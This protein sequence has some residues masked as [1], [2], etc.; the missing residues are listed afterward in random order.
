VAFGSWTWWRVRTSGATSLG[1]LVDDREADVHVVEHR[2]RRRPEAAVLDRVADGHGG[3]AGLGLDA[4]GE[5]QELA[6]HGRLP[7]L[8]LGPQHA[9][10]ALPARPVAQE[11]R[12]RVGDAAVQ[13]VTDF[14]AVGVG[15]VAR[16]LL[17]RAHD[18]VEA[19][20]AHQPREGAQP[21]QA[22]LSVVLVQP[23][24]PKP[25]GRAPAERDAVE[26]QC[27]HV[28]RPVDHQLEGE[29]A[30][31]AEPQNPDA[32]LRAVAMLE[33]LDAEQ[34][35]DVAD[36]AGEL[37]PRQVPAEERGH[38]LGLPGLVRPRHTRARAGGL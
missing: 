27:A 11:P 16:V 25:R 12:R 19:A 29:P 7:D 14:G 18:V 13:A 22:S 15:V 28:H 3:A 36:A 9:A 17:D 1:A 38:R 8:A 23:G 31:G 4:A 21:A 10:L 6:E 37:A 35:R 24:A 2:V 26:F 32:A 34:L 5:D 30:A 20:G 33:Q